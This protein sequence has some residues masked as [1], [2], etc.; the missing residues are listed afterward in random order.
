MFTSTPNPIKTEDVYLV[1]YGTSQ[2]QSQT[3]CR[4]LV[5]KDIIHDTIIGTASE[6]LEKVEI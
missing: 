6:I 1:I 5:I 2:L 3:E 4:K